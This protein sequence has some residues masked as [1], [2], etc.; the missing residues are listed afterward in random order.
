VFEQQTGTKKQIFFAMI[1]AYGI[2]ETLYSE[3]LL[4][5]IVTLKDLYK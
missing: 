5:G 1:S 4:T 2:K 3:D